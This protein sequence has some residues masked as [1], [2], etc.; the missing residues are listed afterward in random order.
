MKMNVPASLPVR[1]NEESNLG[2]VVVVDDHALLAESVV[3]T[4]RASG[5]SACSV[6][7]DCADLVAAVLDRH[8]SLVLLDLFLGEQPDVSFAALASF[9]AASVPVLVVTATN[10]RFL[11]AR[12]LE[13][14]AVGIVEKSS[15]IETLIDAVA[16]TLR[17]ESVMS[18]SRSIELLSELASVRRTV[19]PV[20]LVHTLTP[21]ERDVLQALTLGH[22]AGRIARDNQTSVV[23]V[24][25]HI[26]SVLLKLN[27]HS[28]L[29]AVSIAMRQ[30]WFD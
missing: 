17:S 7:F 2:T 5:F 24:R 12:C 22:P 11:H 6:A 27:V 13:A 10:S 30:N 25:T 28:Q 20:S 15:P 9:A 3:M 23:T 29:E 1:P 4:L 8:P 18:K 16:H 19:E 26:R 14:G 21:R